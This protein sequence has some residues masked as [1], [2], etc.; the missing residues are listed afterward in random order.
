METGSSNKLWAISSLLETVAMAGVFTHIWLLACSCFTV[1]LNLTGTLNFRL[2]PRLCDW[3]LPLENGVP[4]APGWL[5]LL[6]ICLQLR[7]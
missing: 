1:K 7:S 5:S 2:T 4:G 3:R 6:S